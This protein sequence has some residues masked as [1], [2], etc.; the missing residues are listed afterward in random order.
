MIYV[1]LIGIALLLVLIVPPLWRNNQRAKWVAMAARYLFR[2]N[3]VLTEQPQSVQDD[4]MMIAF[5]AYAENRSD[6]AAK[7]TAIRFFREYVI[8][9][10][11]AQMSEVLNE[12]PLV[13]AIKTLT[14]WAAEDFGVSSAVQR[15]L[16]AIKMQLPI[17]QAPEV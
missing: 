14:T 15:T 12:K 4:F 11:R 6:R 5:A 2:L 16:K 10:P 9:Q 17:E 1:F 8:E 3:V 13:A 7:A